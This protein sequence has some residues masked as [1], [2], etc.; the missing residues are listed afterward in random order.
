MEIII[1]DCETA[2]E[3]TARAVHEAARA[4]AEGGAAH[5]GN[6]TWRV[7]RRPGGASHATL[8]KRTT[9]SL[10]DVAQLAAEVR[11]GVD[12]VLFSYVLVETAAAARAAG[13]SS[14]TAPIRCAVLTR[15]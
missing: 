1:A 5:M 15:T 9:R 6:Y 13:A 3:R 10:A 11:S 8:F 12:L 4:V 7:L 2:W 14:A